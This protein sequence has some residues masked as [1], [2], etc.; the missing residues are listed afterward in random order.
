MSLLCRKRVCYTEGEELQEGGGEEQGRVQ[1]Q[2]QEQAREQDQQQE[3]G[4]VPFHNPQEL[5]GAT[6]GLRR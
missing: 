5:S 2:A 6:R 1:R 4:E 3:Q